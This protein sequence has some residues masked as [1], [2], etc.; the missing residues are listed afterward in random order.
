MLKISIDTRPVGRYYF[1]ADA[2]YTFFDQADVGNCSFKLRNDY[3]VLMGYRLGP[4]PFNRAGGPIYQGKQKMKHSNPLLESSLLEQVAPYTVSGYGLFREIVESDGALPAKIKALFVAVAAINKGYPEL[5]QREIA[6]AAALGLPLN[7]A[8]A[9]LIVLSSLRGE[10][11]ALAF[12]AVLDATYPQPSG[13]KAPTPAIEAAA[14]EA[15]NNFKQYFGTVPVALA[16]LLELCPKGADAYYLMRKGSIECNQLSKKY[17]ELMLVTILAADYSPMAATHIKAARNV[18]AS[19]VELA[20][21][22]LCAV[23]SAGI[24]SWISAGALLASA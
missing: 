17:A 19:D 6:R 14:G 23:P 10:G 5:A 22:I 7:E 2:S 12:K 13:A 16:K 24:A 8:A 21:A 15:E 20:E 3:T 18:E 11:A 9:G 1:N 4:T